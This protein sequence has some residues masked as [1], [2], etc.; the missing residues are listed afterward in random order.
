MVT[1]VFQDEISMV[2]DLIPNKNIPVSRKE[3]RFHDIHGNHAIIII[4]YD[5]LHSEELYDSVA[6]KLARKLR[7]FV[8]NYLQQQTLPHLPT[9]KEL[10][11]IK[12]RQCIKSVG[13]RFPPRCPQAR[14]KVI[15]ANCSV[16]AEG[17]V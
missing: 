2:T 1:I 3:P 15:T 4:S 6:E 5:Y 12:Q 17:I 13:R 11:Q 7:D 10:A 16:N 9:P 8:V 14:F